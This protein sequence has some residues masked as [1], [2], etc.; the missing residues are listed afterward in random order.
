MVVSGSSD[1]ERETAGFRLLGQRYSLDSW[2][3]E[4]VTY[5]KLKENASGEARMLPDFLDVPAGM[6]S[7]LALD[8][9]NE[10]S[11]VSKWSDHGLQIEETRKEINAKGDSIYS[12]SVSSAWLGALSKNLESK[13]EWWPVFMNNQLWDKKT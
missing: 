8:I 7:D 6:G 1:V 12:N 10:T 2:I 3:M 5:N 4:N 9:L 11:N 13:S